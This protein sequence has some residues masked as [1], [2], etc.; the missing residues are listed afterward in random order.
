MDSGGGHP[1]C[2]LLTSHIKWASERTVITGMLLLFLKRY[3]EPK[4]KIN[5]QLKEWYHYA[6][7]KA[8]GVKYLRYDNKKTM[9][10][11]SLLE[12]EPRK[13]GVKL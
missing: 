4:H 13:A 8:N 6:D 1:K 2:L 5:M 10:K 12:W 11:T 3:S 7:M 9:G